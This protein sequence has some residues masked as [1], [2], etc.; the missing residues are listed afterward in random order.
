MGDSLKVKGRVYVADERVEIG[1]SDEECGI[2]Y[3]AWVGIGISVSV[4]LLT[5]KGQ[6]DGSE[7]GFM[8]PPE[9]VVGILFIHGLLLYE[10]D[11]GG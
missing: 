2:P 10:I 4:G 3:R 8:S 11:I 5:A 6:N 7:G 1:V 9:I